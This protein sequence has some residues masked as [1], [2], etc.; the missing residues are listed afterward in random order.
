MNFLC[1]LNVCL[2]HASVR[3]VL[4]VPGVFNFRLI[5]IAL[6]VFSNYAASSQEPLMAKGNKAFTLSYGVGNTVR[7]DLKKTLDDQVANNNGYTYELRG[8]NP[9]QANLDIAFSDYTTAGIAVSWCRFA[10]KE[11]G[12]FSNDA[13]TLETRAHKVALQLRGV[14]YIMQSQRAVIYFFG[15]AGIRFR[16]VSDDSNDALKRQLAF[17]HQAGELSTAAYRPYTVEAGLGL[18]FLVTKTLGV[19]AE[20]GMLTGIA[21]VGLFYSFK[22]KWRKSNDQYGW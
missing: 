8:T 4:A 16:K 5:A 10:V 19:S 14:R 9:L 6:F 17:S 21:Q 13:S 20:A 22:N 15:A 12:Q 11:S 3:S 2:C 1:I 18:K 7:I